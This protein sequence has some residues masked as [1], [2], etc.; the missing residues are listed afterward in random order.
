VSGGPSGGYARSNRITYVFEKGLPEGSLGPD[1]TWAIKT[2]DRCTRS[3]EELHIPVD[4]L[5][6][7][8]AD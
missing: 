4:H 8:E 5:V 7:C 2:F 6:S 3:K 1:W